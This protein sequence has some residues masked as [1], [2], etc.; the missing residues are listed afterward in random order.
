MTAHYKVAPLDIPYFIVSLYPSCTHSF[1]LE[2]PNQLPFTL[3]NMSRQS[4][5]LRWTL[6]VMSFMELKS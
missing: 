6:Q 3:Y 4:E 1:V 2:A 5:V